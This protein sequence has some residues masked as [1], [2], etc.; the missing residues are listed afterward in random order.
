MEKAVTILLAIV[1]FIIVL[2]IG[3]YKKIKRKK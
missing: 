2:A 1:V 3:Y